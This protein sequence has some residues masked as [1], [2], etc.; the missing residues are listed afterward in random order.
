MEWI[1][2]CNLQQYAYGKTNEQIIVIMK[3]V[4][5]SVKQ[6]HQQ[7]VYHL[8]LKPENIIVDFDENP[9]I[10]D[11]GS[12]QYG[13]FI[14]C[15]N[16][17]KLVSS[18]QKQVQYPFS[19]E[20]F[21]PVKSKNCQYLADKYDVYQ[22]GCSIYL[23]F[24]KYLINKPLI[25]FSEESIQ[26]Y[27]QLGENLQD[28]LCGMLKECQE[29]RYSLEQVIHHPVFTEQSLTSFRIDHVSHIRQKLHKF[30]N[31]Q[32]SYSTIKWNH[33]PKKPQSKDDQSI[34][35][36]CAYNPFDL[37]LI[38]KICYQHQLLNVNQLNQ[39]IDGLHSFALN[40]IYLNLN[41]DSK[42][43]EK[44]KIQYIYDQD[45]DSEFVPYRFQE[46]NGDIVIQSKKPKIA[47]INEHKCN[48]ISDSYMH[49][50]PKAI[51]CDSVVQSFSDYTLVDDFA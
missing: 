8:D 22:L 41:C 23:L 18:T 49:L 10:V 13:Q 7:N 30:H 47:C 29:L 34:I 40:H 35:I 27:R 45:S 4:I 48:C 24:T 50:F 6:M 20:Q 9:H 21:S 5:N 28:L 31:Y 2:G 25:R 36:K 15:D 26:L 17:N 32:R 33:V 46:S 38:Q 3:I 1:D 11:L 12:C 51:S 42:Q 14:S 16:L 37:Q 39:K 44:I 43:Q 19:T